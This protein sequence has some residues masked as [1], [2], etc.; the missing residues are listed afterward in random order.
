MEDDDFPDTLD[1][2]EFA[3]PSGATQEPPKEDFP[4]TLDPR[5]FDQFPETLSPADFD[6]SPSTSSVPGV[7]ARGVAEGA[8]PAVSGL[9]A[10]LRVGTMLSPA[11]PVVATVG[12]LA[13]GLGAG[14][15]MATGQDKVMELMGLRDSGTFSREQ[16]QTDEAQHPYVKWAGEQAPAAVLL[17]PLGTLGQRAIGAGIGAVVGAGTDYAQTGHVDPVK[18]ALSAGMGAA[19]PT[20]N[21]WGEAAAGGGGSEPPRP[22]APGSLPPDPN[23]GAP[24][25]GEVLPPEPGG[26][27]YQNTG[28][29]AKD[30]QRATEQRDAL[31]PADPMWQHWNTYLAE[32]QSRADGKG[33]I[34]VDASLGPASDDH[35]FTYQMA[36]RANDVTTT[37][38][39]VAHENSPAPQVE[40]AGNPVGAPMEARTAQRPSGA[41]RDYRKLPEPKPPDAEPT[42][43]STVVS[44][45]PIHEDLAAALAPR[46]QSAAPQGEA[47]ATP[48]V[49]EP[50]PAPVEQPPRAAPEPAAQPEVTA[51]VTPQE[52]HIASSALKA[53]QKAGMQEAARRLQALPPKEQAVAATKLLQALSSKSGEAGGNATEVRVPF[54]RQELASGVM[55]RS[56]ADVA[57]KQGVLD[58]YESAVAKHPPGENETN[59]QTLDRARTMVKDAD[60]LTKGET[61]RPNVK[62]PSWQ[63][64]KQAR[65][66]LR[67]PTPENVDKFRQA[68]ALV[69]GEKVA[70][71]KSLDQET[72]RIDS[73]IEHKPQI[74]DAAAEAL[75]SQNQPAAGRPEHEHFNNEKGDESAV[76][77]RE[78]NGL[79]QWLNNLSDE[80]HAAL[81]DAHPDLET[82]VKA[83]QDPKALHDEL[84]DDL[85]DWQAK[86]LAPKAEFEV[87]PAETARPSKRT[88][89]KSRADLDA[90]EPG[91]P[92]SVGKSLKGSPEFDKLAAQ[93]GGP[94]PK[95]NAVYDL[96]H[97][98]AQAKPVDGSDQSL[99]DHLTRFMRDESGAVP[100]PHW[101]Q[102]IGRNLFS[103]RPDQHVLDYGDQIGMR[104]VH[105]RTDIAMAKQEALANARVAVYPDGSLPTPAEFGKM[106]RA[107]EQGTV[108]L[109]SA[110]QRQY[111]ND[112]ITPVQRKAEAAYDEL[113][114]LSIKH[115][116]SGWDEMPV[117]KNNGNG[118]TEFTFRRLK[119]DPLDDTFEPITNRSS[120]SNWAA[121]AMERDWFSLQNVDTGDRHV[122]HVNEDGKMVLY[123]NHN[124]GRAKTFPSSFNPRDI[125]AEIM[126]GNSR[127][128]V[129]HATI[130]ELMAH[131]NGKN[132][133]PLKYSD[134]PVYVVSDAFV[135][136]KAAL[137]RVK[138]LDSLLTDQTF[139]DLS[140]FQKQK[141][142]TMW[143]KDN[144]AKTI[145][146]QLKDRYMPKPLAWA[147]DDLVKTG[148]NYNGNQALEALSRF[149]QA[150]LKPFYFLGPEVHVF[151]ELD[152]FLIGRGY[153]NMN[154]PATAK[155]FMRG[156]QSVRAQDGLQKEIMAAGGNPMFIHALTARVMPQ[157]AKIV[158]EDSAVRPWKY[159]PINKV[160]GVNTKEVAQ[161]MYQASNKA[162][163]WQS[164]VLY[165]A[166]YSEQKAKGLSPEA[167]VHETEKIIDSYVVPTT[168]G[169]SIGLEGTDLG[170]ALQKVLTDPTTAVFGRFHY[171]LYKMA[172]GIVKNMFGFNSTPT[173]R[174]KGASQAAMLMLMANFVYPALSAGYAKL[175]GN[176][177]SEV[178]KRGLTKVAT[179]PLEIAHG[180]KDIADAM[181]TA[182][183]MAPA[184]DAALRLHENKDFAGRKLIDLAGPTKRVPGQV[185]EFAADTLVSPVAAASRGYEQGGGKFALQRFIES[186]MGLKTP[187]PAG[188]K[189]EFQREKH[190]A[191][192]AKARFKRPRGAIEGLFNKVTN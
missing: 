176:P 14:L 102:T 11:G 111:V 160:F 48:A 83:T 124:P 40:G 4:E 70:D 64:I 16:Q 23:G 164:D 22:R 50:R 173:Q 28:K 94:S 79:T 63:V 150:M 134:N 60:A 27:G 165:T 121:S 37:S 163:W 95:K 135:G 178:E 66:M 180:K 127:M 119:T 175:T 104:G 75:I 76:Y 101:M 87:Q 156:L 98:E 43:P 149:S 148:F 36:D 56:K 35:P 128:K 181:R 80:S 107:M 117:R 96:A 2:Q 118:F 125:G 189:F 74:E 77:T 179:L 133:Q 68:E 3:G 51:A 69:G 114:A 130:D 53:L 122:Y 166:L 61:Y 112:F 137:A 81:L 25:N 120:L 20:A 183:S 42:Q 26:L 9:A 92:A 146:P 192:D 190:Q 19:F 91:A 123:K 15:L 85:S 38:V 109:L 174:I 99:Q 18:V 151:N 21:R 29:F 90:T 7:A 167:A 39:G 52:Q 31:D 86:N 142:D 73:D 59:G 170:R 54:K 100:I 157:I 136:L 41:L 145:L 153:D 65:D 159:D 126:M 105:L 131:G 45:A 30:I 12:G 132:G 158:G 143:G 1:P 188:T 55:G 108:P 140:T 17:S 191:A 171:G 138:L 186:N 84:M 6:A 58:A 24:L 44:Q 169:K 88:P 177:Q 162:M 110:K 187:S 116:L 47:A 115:Q 62:P 172:A 152:K 184:T 168:F 89:I 113:R 161:R 129:E 144:H 155:H 5:A 97:E 57:R 32:L 71:Q 182:W 154:L 78:H 93:Y 34:D 106:Y 141:A 8:I 72:S 103:A 67:K 82:N 49:A 139:K 185:A 46:E 147:L 10:G 13:A 33:G